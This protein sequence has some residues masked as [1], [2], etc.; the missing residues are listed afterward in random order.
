MAKRTVVSFGVKDGLPVQILSSIIA[1]ITM[2]LA[3]N[4]FDVITTRMFNQ[5]VENGKGVLYKNWADC[6][7]KTWKTEGLLGMYKGLVPHYARLAPHTL[8]LLV[9]FDQFSKLADH[10]NL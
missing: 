4:P 10:W 3:L 5:K 2:S 8:L 7:A 9:L 1:G 6:F